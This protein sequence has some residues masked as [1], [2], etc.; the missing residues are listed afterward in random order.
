MRMEIYFELRIAP[1][2]NRDNLYC[3]SLALTQFGNTQHYPPEPVLIEAALIQLLSD[4]ICRLMRRNLVYLIYYRIL[5]VV[6]KIV[7]FPVHRQISPFASI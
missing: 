6:C 3:R 1:N 7:T 4:P 5:D 2:S